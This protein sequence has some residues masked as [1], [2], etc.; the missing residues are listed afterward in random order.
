MIPSETAAAIKK[1]VADG[2]SGLRAHKPQPLSEWAE[3]NFVLA[4]ESSQQRGQWKAWTFQIGV[5][6][7]M[8]DDRIRELAVQKSKRVGYS[9]M[10]TAFVAYNIA[11]RRRNQ[12][13]WQPTDDDRDSYEKS[14]IRPILDGVPVVKAMRR[15]GKER[16]TINLKR[17]LGSVLHLLGGKAARAYRRITVAVAILDEWSAF[18][19]N[20]EKS[21]DPGGLAKG[22]L[23]GAAY[24]KFV[25][26]S[27]PR[28]K[29]L[30][31]VERAVDESEEIVRYHITCPHCDADHPL[32]WSANKKTGMVW[33]PGRPE[34][35]R[36]VCPHC[37]GEI[38][39]SE[40]LVAGEPPVGE[41]VGEKTGIRFGA[42][43]IWRDA[44]G[45]PCDPPER[46]GVHIW[47]AYSPQRDWP[48]IVRE[49]ENAQKVLE[50]GEEGPAQLFA[51]ETLGVTWEKVGESGDEHALQ[52]RAEDYRLETVPK[53]GLAL[54]AGVDVQRNRWEI[55]VWAWG[56]GLESWIVDHMVIEGNPSIPD[57]WDRVT[58]ALRR[59]YPHEL[60]GSMG[61]GAV[62]VDSSDQTQ[63]VYS[64]AYRAQSVIRN[65]RVIKGASQQA[66]PI[67]GASTPIEV[68]YR[69][70][71]VLNGLH[72]WEVGVHAAKDLLLGQLGIANPGPG[73]IHF[74]KD[75]PN[76]FYEQL[77]GEKR[78]VSL[79][80]GQPAHKW[81]RVRR[82]EALD[83]RNYALYSSLAMRLDRMTEWQWQRL[84]DG[85]KTGEEKASSQPIQVKRQG[86][87]VY[88]KGIG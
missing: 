9:K 75:L 15:D 55:S 76:E 83:C 6:D 52:A 69:G 50:R 5:L 19:L 62:A 51:N 41:W 79:V 81:V 33:E 58:E 66:K 48:S 88:S 32:I 28:V 54:T 3:E 44:M 59:I 7:W 13:I 2:L 65:L 40:Y 43:K 56:P 4:G 71:K 74:S 14:E 57:E 78:V 72:K 31:H 8:S 37:E 36:H 86:R 27:T 61:I 85:L 23:E 46:L 87:R 35:V 10:V 26:G 73:Y 63:D 34:T 70:R 25:G 80:N 64:W 42:D 84:E 38:R 67:V 30:C 21:G 12:A 82:N 16:E 29:G 22:R 18:D 20:I 60:G 17:F 1:A 68:T 11:H 47:S 39:Q 24:P 53:G 45:V 49:Y 77:T